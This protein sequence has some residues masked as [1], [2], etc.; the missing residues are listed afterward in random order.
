MK[1]TSAQRDSGR[2]AANGKPVVSATKAPGDAL[3]TLRSFGQHSSGFLA[4]NSGNEYFTVDGSSGMIVYRP[5]GRRYWV[6]FAGPIA[7]P[8]ECELLE[9]SFAAAAARQRRRIIGVQL[10]RADAERAARNGYIVNQFGCSYSIDLSQF[11]MT[12]R[13][14]HSIRNM[15][16]RSRREGI[17]VSEANPERQAQPEFI[18]RL[19]EMDAAWLRSKG[20]HAKE[21]RFLIGERGGVFQEHR[22]VFVAEQ[23]GQPIAYQTYSP[24]F[25][26]QSGWLGDLERRLPGAPPGAADHIFAEA[27]QQFRDEGAG[28]V[29]LGLTP[30]VGIDPAHAVDGGSSAAVT[31]AIELARKHGAALYPAESQ[32]AFKLKW[33]PHVITPEYIAFPGGPRVRDVWSLARVT[34]A[35]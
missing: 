4:L 23:D 16:A 10:L 12:G 19:A 2:P 17:T 5:H 26:A 33:R 29:H 31:K 1:T 22:R 34:N 9:Q 28:W 24:V 20:W 7:A 6:Q 32:L 30:F 25:G 3:A 27:A 14:W 15:I 13:K 11:S 35:L 18:D 21:L 8:E